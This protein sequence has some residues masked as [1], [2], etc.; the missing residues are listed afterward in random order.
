MWQCGTRAQLQGDPAMRP[1]ETKPPLACAAH[2][3]CRV[4]ARAGHAAGSAWASSTARAVLGQSPHGNLIRI[5]SSGLRDFFRIP[6]NR[7]VVYSF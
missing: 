2:A 1:S 4:S 5:F 7:Q 6:T 3:S